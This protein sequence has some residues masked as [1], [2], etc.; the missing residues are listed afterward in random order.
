MWD[1]RKLSVLATLGE[2]GRGVSSLRS[3]AC[4]IFLAAAGASGLRVFSAKT[5]EP[6]CGADGDS[7]GDGGALMAGFAPH[8]RAIVGVTSKEAFAC[9]APDA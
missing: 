7:L 1:L 8:A 9:A 2:A 6:L 3:D 5:W 4:G